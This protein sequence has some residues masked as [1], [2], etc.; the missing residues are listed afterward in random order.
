M[1]SPGAP[2][3]VSTGFDKVCCASARW[4]RESASAGTGTN[5]SLG[6]VH[7]REGARLGARGRRG[8]GGFA[9]AGGAVRRDAYVRARWRRAG[10]VDSPERY[11]AAEVAA[12]RA[13]A[14]SGMT[15][16]VS[17]CV[18][19]RI[20]ASESAMGRRTNFE[21]PA[22]M[23]S[24]THAAMSCADRR[25]G[26]RAGRDFCIRTRALRCA[27]QPAHPPS[28]AESGNRRVV[29]IIDGRR[30]SLRPHGSRHDG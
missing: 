24:F 22:S 4:P 3:A 6:S 20:S 30:F 18:C 7:Q 1:R 5:A 13:L 23:Y 19:A 27:V 26:S 8:G 16:S 10:P 11:P 15:S 25:R 21:I 17:R 29:V 14:K 2:V 9:R 28:R 12:T